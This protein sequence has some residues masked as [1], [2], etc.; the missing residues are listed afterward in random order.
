MDEGGRGV[1]G[2]ESEEDKR[3]REARSH[4]LFVQVP[5]LA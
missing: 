3:G 4:E 2:G 5:I 1:N